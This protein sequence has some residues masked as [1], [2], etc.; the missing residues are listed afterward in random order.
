MLGR[1]RVIDD[2]DGLR[3]LACKDEGNNPTDKGEA[4]EEV[5]DDNSRFVRAVFLDGR[6]GRQEKDI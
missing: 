3:L 5:E 4:K 2:Y 1:W 6:D